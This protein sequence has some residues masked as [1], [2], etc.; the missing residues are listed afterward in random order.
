MAT[1]D[2]ETVLNNVL[3]VPTLL[4]MVLA[5]GA[6]I[7]RLLGVRVGVVRTLAGG[8]PRAAARRAA[9]RGDA[10]GPGAGRH[11]H[12]AAVPAARGL[13]RQPAGDGRPGDRRGDRPR[14]LA[15]RPDR[16]LA[17][18]AH[19]GGPDPPLLA[20][21][22]D[23]RCGTGSAGSCAGSGTPGLESPSSR[24]EL[25]RSV[26]RALDE[27][28]VT[29]VKLGQQLSTRRDLM[30]AGV[31]RRAGAAAGPGGAGALGGRQPGARARARPAGRRGVRRR[32]TASRWPPPRSPRC[33]PARLPDGAEVVVKVQRPGHRAGRR[34]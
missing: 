24:R 9:D 20:D 34:P 29:F 25:A 15:A 19:A 1:M 11:R 22:A 8:G 28:G 23:R 27:G 4:L 3:F 7:R 32:S 14:R 10:A 21:P 16:A 26:R 12:G 33:T 13:L 18:L 2:G 5:F 17:R 30:P 6:V 31:R